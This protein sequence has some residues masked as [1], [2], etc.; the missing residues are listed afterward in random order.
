MWTVFYCIAVG[1]VVVCV[2]SQLASGCFGRGCYCKQ[3]VRI[4]TVLSGARDDL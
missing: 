1:R 4:N 2:F 3:N